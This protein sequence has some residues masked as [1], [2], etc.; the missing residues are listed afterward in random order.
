[1]FKNLIG[2]DWLA[3][4][5]VSYDINPS[6]ARDVGEF[7]LADPAQARQALPVSAG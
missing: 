7:A 2:R 6:D 3:G 4:P 1:M 5:R